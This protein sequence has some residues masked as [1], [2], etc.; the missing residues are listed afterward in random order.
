M[1]GRI[2]RILVTTAVAAAVVATTAGAC[3]KP[4]DPSN[5]SEMKEKISKGSGLMLWKL[6]ATKDQEKRLDRLFDGVAPDF[7]AYQQESKA[8]QRKVMTA[9]EAETIDDAELNR[10]QASATALFDRYMKRLVQAAR[11]AAGIFTLDQRRKLI[12]VWREWEFGE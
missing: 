9:L 10:L 6:D 12:K 11:D 4:A 5:A 3:R 1:T 8:I 2:A 7:L